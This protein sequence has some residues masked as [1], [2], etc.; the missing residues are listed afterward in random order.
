MRTSEYAAPAISAGV[1]RACGSPRDGQGG[2]SLLEVTI[3]ML[4]LGVVGLGAAGLFNYSIKYGAVAAARAQTLTVAQQQMERLQ[5]VPFD[6]ALLAPTADP[7]NPPQQHVH[8]GDSHFVVSRT[9]VTQDDV[10]VGGVTRPTTKLIT[11]NITPLI[12]GAPW[13]TGTVTITARRS[14]PL[15]GPY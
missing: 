5:S 1:P 2:F 13:A 6:D 15:R 4:I 9:V 3:S 8:S 7:A 14:T 12:N 10:T 11:L